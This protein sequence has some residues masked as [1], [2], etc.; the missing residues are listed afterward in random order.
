MNARLLW[1]AARGRANEPVVT[2]GSN[3]RAELQA[4]TFPLRKHFSSAP[5]ANESAGTADDRLPCVFA[6][7]F[8]AKQ[9]KASS[10]RSDSRNGKSTRSIGTS[11]QSSNPVYCALM[12]RE[13][14]IRRFRQWQKSSNPPP[15][16][17]A[18]SVHPLCRCPTQNRIPNVYCILLPTRHLFRIQNVCTGC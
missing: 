16:H 9:T 14:I 4:Q 13:P 12:P 7:A 15:I 17:L 6:Y 3:I 2:F 10:S 11:Q 1:F 18:P 8:G 5:V